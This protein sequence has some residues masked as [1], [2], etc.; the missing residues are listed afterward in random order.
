MASNLCRQLARE[1]ET[2][3]GKGT[4]GEWHKERQGGK[5]PDRWVD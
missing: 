5:K 3:E 4:L 2:H 1:R